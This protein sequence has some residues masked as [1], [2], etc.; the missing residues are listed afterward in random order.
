VSANATVNTT[1]SLPGEPAGTNT[2]NIFR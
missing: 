1:P 2:V